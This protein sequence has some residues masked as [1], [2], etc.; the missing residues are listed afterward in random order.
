MPRPIIAPHLHQ[1]TSCYRL[2]SRTLYNDTH[3]TNG[4]CF[5]SLNQADVCVDCWIRHAKIRENLETA[6]L[7]E[8]G[9]YLP[10]PR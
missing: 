7:L 9:V 4:T 2:I 8:A 3:V 1:C 6:G 10:G 5:S